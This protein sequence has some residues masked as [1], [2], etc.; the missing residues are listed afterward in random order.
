M[1]RRSSPCRYRPRSKPSRS[2]TRRTNSRTGSV[3][4][5]GVWGTPAPPG[6]FLFSNQS[7]SRP[8]RARHSG[9][10]GC[11]QTV[12]SLP[13]SLGTGRGGSRTH[14]FPTGIGFRTALRM[15]R[16]AARRF[17]SAIRREFLS[18]G[19]SVGRPKVPETIPKASKSRPT[20]S[21]RLPDAGRPL[22]EAIS[23]RRRSLPVA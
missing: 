1:A 7:S 9:T 16:A 21:W 13:H 4:P 3:Q 23:L 18:S 10:G 19:L 5:G 15:Y 22:P 14:S 17:R 2:R 20:D 6:F 12:S 8:I 11:V